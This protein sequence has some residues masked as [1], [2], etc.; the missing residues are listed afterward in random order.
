MAMSVRETRALDR[1]ELDFVSHEFC[2]T[3][4]VEVKV[5]DFFWYK[6]GTKSE[7]IKKERI[8]IL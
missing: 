8:G 1:M 4:R 6:A 5:C 3:M 7:T 2:A